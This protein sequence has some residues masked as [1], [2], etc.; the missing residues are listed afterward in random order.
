[1]EAFGLCEPRPSSL[2]I[3]SDKNSLY[4][5]F[6][7]RKLTNKTHTELLPR[8]KQTS[9]IVKTVEY[10]SI[11]YLCNNQKKIEIKISLKAL[12]AYRTVRYFSSKKMYINCN[13][14]Q[15]SFSL[16]NYLLFIHM[17]SWKYTGTTHNLLLAIFIRNNKTM[18]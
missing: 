4:L 3:Y 17:P 5:H 9:V 10:I 12:E 15:F 7:Q 11:S 14:F 1:M 16:K 18:Q 6:K 8:S 13:L 2:W